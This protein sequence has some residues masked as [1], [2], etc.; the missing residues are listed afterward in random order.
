MPRNYKE[1][2]DHYNQ[3]PDGVRKYFLDLEELLKNSKWE[4]SI[5]YMFSR[6][7]QAKRRT[8]YCGIVKKHWCDANLTWILVNKDYL[9]RQRF[10]DLF[11]I[12][13]DKKI[14]TELVEKLKKGEKV[15]DK[16]SHGMSWKPAEAR[17]GVVSLLDFSEEFD[18]FVYELDNFRPFGNLKGF[19]GRKVPLTKSTTRWV[20]KGMG[21]PKPESSTK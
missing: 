7:E 12:V 2:V 4:I 5:S 18:D 17:E 10:Y 11:E 20:L 15:R 14:P 16:I 1:V 6:I 8:I 21:I 9:S 19:K 13:F 3:I